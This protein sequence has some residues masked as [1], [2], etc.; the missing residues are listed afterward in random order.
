MATDSSSQS[1]RLYLQ[2]IAAIPLLSHEQLCE[3]VRQAKEGDADANREIVKHNQ[4]LVISIAKRYVWLGVPFMDLV[5]AGN[6]GLLQAGLHFDPERGSQFS[7]Y[8]IWWI[9]GAIQQELTEMRQVVSLKRGGQEDMDAYTR[10]SEAF[11]SQY[12]RTPT[13]AELAARLQ[14]SVN[15][16]QEIG[17]I[18]RR[19]DSPPKPV[20]EMEAPSR[21]IDAIDA[22]V[23]VQ[24]LVQ[25]LP[26]EERTVL[27]LRWDER[28][29]L[30]EIGV[31]LGIS[32][33][34]VRQ[35]EMSALQ[36]MR[37]RIPAEL[38]LSEAE[39]QRAIAC[40]TMKQKIGLLLK[41][42]RERTRTNEDVGKFLA[43]KRAAISL[44]LGRAED[45]LREALQQKELEETL[46]TRVVACLCLECQALLRKPPQQIGAL[47]RMTVEQV[48]SLRVQL[49]ADLGESCDGK[50]N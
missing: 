27:Y 7:T 33:E 37:E 42:G 4:R 23:D 2:G 12:G 5:Q 44:L 38:D 20:A 30:E 10:Q 21:D 29:T 46:L 13:D 19:F 36:R 32:P 3:L 8:A 17:L 16:V 28:M 31:H 25:Y 22:R 14:W 50:E 41:Y 49:T 40:L 1:E 39:I 9:K 11:L 18:K 6:V 47:L 26:E 45:R 24:K 35:I 43:V 48:R 15:K 34:R